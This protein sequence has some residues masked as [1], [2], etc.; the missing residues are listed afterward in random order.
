MLHQLWSAGQQT[1]ADPEHGIEQALNIQFPSGSEI[2]QHLRELPRYSESLY[3]THL[4]DMVT[5]TFA[6]LGIINGEEVFPRLYDFSKPQSPLKD[7]LPATAA[8]ELQLK[9]RIDTGNQT[10]AVVRSPTGVSLVCDAEATEIVVVVKGLDYYG[11]PTLAAVRRDTT[12]PYMRGGWSEILIIDNLGQV[13]G[14]NLTGGVSGTESESH[15]RLEALWVL[16]GS[17]LNQITNPGPASN[18]P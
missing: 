4:D 7:Y 1:L 10:N 16:L 3:C 18:K 14:S 11:E 8:L 12:V 6:R 13:V 17:T 15:A 2:T 5:E 9:D